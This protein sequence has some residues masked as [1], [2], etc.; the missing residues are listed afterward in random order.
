[1]LVNFSLFSPRTIHD[2][3]DFDIA[4][5]DMMSTHPSHHRRGAGKMLVQWG[6]D[7]ADK[8]GVEAFIEGTL[9][10]QNLYQSC[11]FRPVPNEYIY[12]DVPEKWKGR[13]QVKYF[14][15]ERQPKAIVGRG[16][17]IEEVKNVVNVEIK[18]AAAEEVS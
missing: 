15:M 8:M 3:A 4:V 18:E 13:P 5:L 6:C 14:F 10:A 9:I 17:T 2:E 16:E 12:V 7:I 1:M 11:G